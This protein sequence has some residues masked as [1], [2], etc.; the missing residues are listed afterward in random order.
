MHLL[1]THDINLLRWSVSCQNCLEKRQAVLSP[2]CLRRRKHNLVSVFTLPSLCMDL[3]HSICLLS[4]NNMNDPGFSTSHAHTPPAL[5]YTK[6]TPNFQLWA[7]SS[8]RN[9][10]VFKGAETSK[11][12]FRDNTTLLYFKRNET[13]LG[14]LLEIGGEQDNLAVNIFSGRHTLTLNLLFIFL[15]L[16][17]CCVF[18]LLSSLAL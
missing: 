4:V 11:C 6:E 9:T 13:L 10:L 1:S 7:V 16:W 17:L 3:A 8:V 2:L 15:S 12:W 5:K 14:K 18:L